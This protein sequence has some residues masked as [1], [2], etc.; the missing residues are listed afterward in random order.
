MITPTC[1]GSTRPCAID[2]LGLRLQVLLDGHAG[3]HLLGD[4]RESARICCETHSVPLP[5]PGR[6][7]LTAAARTR[8]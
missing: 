7:D 5:R 1:T 8:P 6:G 2:D 4:L 3:R